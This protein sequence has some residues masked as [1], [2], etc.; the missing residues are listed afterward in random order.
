LSHA[1][2]I[3]EIEKNLKINTKDHF[4]IIYPEG[5]S[6]SLG[7][8]HRGI[9]KDGRNVVIKIKYPE[10][11]KTL[12]RDS[13]KLGLLPALGGGL[14]GKF[15]PNK[16]KK[17]VRQVL[18]EEVDYLHEAAMMTR[19][20]ELTSNS[21]EVSVPE[22]FPALSNEKTLTMSSM[23]GRA[24]SELTDW[25]LADH[26]ELSKILL[27]FFLKNCLQWGFIHGDPHQ[28]NI[29]FS[30]K[31]DRV[32][33][34]FLNFGCVKKLK[35]EQIR[36]LN[37]L[38]KLALS[39]N[40]TGNES[41]VFDFYI[42][43][44]FNPDLLSPMADRLVSLTKVFFKP[45]SVKG[46]FTLRAWDLRNQVFTVLGNYQVNF[47]AAGPANLIFFIRAY[48]GLIQYLKV[49][50]CPLNWAELA[51]ECLNKSQSKAPGRPPIDVSSRPFIISESLNIRVTEKGKEKVSLIFKA[52]A[53][54]NLPYIL[55]VDLKEKLVARSIDIKK[56]ADRVVRSNFKP[57]KLFC[58]DEGQKKIR[59]WLK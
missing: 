55:P 44:G 3:T 46:P 24:F 26:Y 37:G 4:S 52:Q 11:N 22:I 45:F 35:K 41:K 23:E 49:Y 40:L 5:I 17:E 18:R 8:I 14:N 43:L 16:Y 20:S 27:K 30:K 10:I 36:A 56:I 9:L 57:G 59:G 15:A 31:K 7:Q 25:S 19:F 28:G 51:R 38:L 48:Q 2:A 13:K 33:V 29:R 1:E 50:D 34:G 54:E 32:H 39:D 47:R 58:F 53:A 42:S 6:S 12:D 21:D